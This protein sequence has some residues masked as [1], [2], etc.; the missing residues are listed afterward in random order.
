MMDAF[1]IPVTAGSTSSCVCV[2]ACSTGPLL[3][4]AW[5]FPGFAITNGA[6]HT[7]VHIF[8]GLFLGYILRNGIAGSQAECLW[9]FDITL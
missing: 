7:S 6:A 9:N 5:S 4:A 2:T 1:L 3:V 8:A